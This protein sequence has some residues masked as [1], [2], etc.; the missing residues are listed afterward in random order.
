MAIKTGRRFVGSELKTAY[1]NQAVKNIESA[2][3]D[4]GGLF[5]L[6]A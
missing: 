3:H 5:A 4:Q 6:E 2:R 1:F